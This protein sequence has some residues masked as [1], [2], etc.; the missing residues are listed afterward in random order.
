MPPRLAGVVLS[1][2]LIGGANAQAIDGAARAQK[3]LRELDDLW[4]GQSSYGVST[5]VVRT[6]HYTR[7]LKLEGWSQGRE[8]TFIRI[9]APLREKGTTTL[10]SGNSIYTYLPK[11][12]RTIR[13]TSGM[14]MGA[15][16]GSHFTNDDLVRESRKEL[17]YDAVVTFEGV[18]DNRD[19]IEFTLTPKPDAPVVW[20]KVV[21]MIRAADYLPITETYYDEDYKI[22]RTIY[23]ED[24]RELGGRILPTTLRVVPADA[25]DE[26]T[27][28]RYERLEFDVPIEDGFF[29]VAR[30][31]RR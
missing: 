12:D 23:F 9:L 30:L 28:L 2:V 25:P 20:G 8:K 19:I 22:A 26:Y 16:M 27:E 13:L 14:M 5:M 4:R 7:S 21:L 24:I 6:A 15:W 18:R 29:A 31:K 17:D 3:I 1:L 11:T 10:K